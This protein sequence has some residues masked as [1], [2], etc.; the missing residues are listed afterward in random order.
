M[1][2]FILALSIFVANLRQDIPIAIVEQ[3]AIV[4][5]FISSSSPSQCSLLVSN[6]ASQVRLLLIAFNFIGPAATPAKYT[7]R[8]KQKHLEVWQK[9]LEV[10]LFT[11]KNT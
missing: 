7:D 4:F 8:C 6:R 2:D 1:I 9:H 11:I 3:C 10:F 5:N